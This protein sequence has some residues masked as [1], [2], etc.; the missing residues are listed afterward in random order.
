MKLLVTGATG[1]AGSYFIE[2]L[3]REQPAVEIV[4]TTRAAGTGWTVPNVLYVAVDLS[5]AHEDPLASEMLRNVLQG[6][7]GVVNFASWARVG[8]SFDRPEDYLHNNINLTI[9]LLEAWRRLAPT[10]CFLHVSTSE[11]YGAV[12]ADAYPD[13]IPETAPIAPISP[14]AASKVA[15]EMAAFAYW[16]S[17]KLPL[18]VAR[19]F[20]YINSRRAD[21]VATAWAYQLAC[22]EAGRQEPTLRH[23][24]LA[25]VRTF[26]SI[27][28]LCAAYWRLL[29]YGIP[30]NTYNVGSTA[31]VALRCLLAALCG[32]ARIPPITMQPNQA[33][34]RPA[35]IP[36]Q[37]PNA[38]KI[39]S[40]LGWCTTDSSNL[41]T[42]A[43]LLMAEMR[44]KVAVEAK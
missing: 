35:D 24:N 36:Y 31:P 6:V 16:R 43:Q 25:S 4:G 34:V 1:A 20:G 11:V 8:E 7:D 9:N 19:S 12:S 15:Q 38:D 23:G 42:M 17:Y 39:R 22:I 44:A 21:L 29:I 10:A 28:D 5:L 27:E 13:G 33:L 18:V 37:V 2:W 30:G 40:R 14:Y 26:C 3:Q 41:A 32:E